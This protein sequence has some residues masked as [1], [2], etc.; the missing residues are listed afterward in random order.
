M[1]AWPLDFGTGER[2][3]GSV[4]AVAF[5]SVQNL[6]PTTSLEQCQGGGVNAARLHSDFGT[7]EPFSIPMPMRCF[8]FF[9]NEFIKIDAH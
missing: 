6:I 4:A 3:F 7:V 2:P 5:G 8:H 9:A 1:T